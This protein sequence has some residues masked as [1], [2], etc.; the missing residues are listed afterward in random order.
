MT[1]ALS[2]AGKGVDAERKLKD[3]SRR[4]ISSR[5]RFS[6]FSSSRRGVVSVLLLAPAPASLLL[7]IGADTRRVSNLMASPTPISAVC[8][9]CSFRTAMSRSI[10]GPM[11]S[12]ALSDD[13]RCM[14]PG[15]SLPARIF[16]SVP[17]PVSA[18]AG[19]D[20]IV[21]FLWSDVSLG[22]EVDRGVRGGLLLLLLLWPPP[23]SLGPGE[24]DIG[25]GAVS[26]ATGMR[27][28]GQRKLAEVK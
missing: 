28:M 11:I 22:A 7:I 25:N 23:P 5:T 20:I 16:A 4:S 13:D 9:R 3:S 2:N 8:A 27:T 12:T 10:M 18:A 24:L 1:Q 19:T 26:L 15:F 17:V 21:S 6:S 14:L